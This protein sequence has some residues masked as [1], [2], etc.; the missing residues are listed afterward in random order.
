VG[1]EVGHHPAGDVHDA[2]ALVDEG[3]DAGGGSHPVTIHAMMLRL[4]LLNVKTDLERELEKLS[5]K[6]LQ[7]RPRRPVG[8]GLGTTPGIWSHAEPAPH[9]EPAV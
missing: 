7:V 5:L 8:S 2:L 9:G 4:E 1:T 6:L 3:A